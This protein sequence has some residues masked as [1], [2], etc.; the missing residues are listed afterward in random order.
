VTASPHS[1]RGHPL[2]A[3][4]TCPPRLLQAAALQQARRAVGAAG[5]ARRGMPLQPITPPAGDRGVRPQLSR[6]GRAMGRSLA[7]ANIRPQPSAESAPFAA[8]LQ[9]CCGPPS[10]AQVYPTPAF[11]PL[12]PAAHLL[13]V[14]PD[15]PQTPLR[16][17][18]TAPAP[19]RSR[20][21]RSGV[22]LISTA[23]D[24]RVCLLLP[25]NR[26]AR[27]W[28]MLAGPPIAS[29]LEQPH[30]SAATTTRARELPPRA[31]EVT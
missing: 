13:T 7:A 15:C 26:R 12:P 17:P 4:A 25:C 16:G 30:L 31:C 6:V 8:A 1:P 28:R 3:L 24:A 14:L 2:R 27:R 5:L 19:W 10:S 23:R 22:L 11:A 9:G 20:D 18:N 29:T 21:L